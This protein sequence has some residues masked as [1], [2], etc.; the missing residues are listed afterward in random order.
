MANGFRR[1][2]RADERAHTAAVG[3]VA[4]MLI[5]G[6]T[7]AA[8]V[9]FQNE[10][11]A[12]HDAESEDLDVKARQALGLIVAQSGSTSTGLA[13]WHSDADRL[14]RFGLAS[15][16]ATRTLEYGKI[17]NLRSSKLTEDGANAIADY[18]EV[19]R[20]LGLQGYNIHL[21]SYPVLLSMEDSR[22]T[23]HAD[24]RPAYVAQYDDPVAPADVTHSVV[25]QA[26]YVEPG[27][28]ITNRHVKDAIYQVTF[29]LNTTGQ[30]NAQV[31]ETHYTKLLRPGDTDYVWTRYYP[32][33]SWTSPTTS[34]EVRVAD[35]YMA[36]AKDTSGN[37]IGQRFFN[38]VSMPASGNE[39]YNLLVHADDQH[40]VSGETVTILGDHF[41]KDGKRSNQGIQGRLTVTRPDGTVHFNGTLDLE[42]NKPG[43]YECTT[44]TMVGNWS[45]LLTTTS[46]AR[47][48]RDSFHVS[49][50]AMF[51]ETSGPDPIAI[52]EQGYV[53]AIAGGSFDATLYD[54]ATNPGGDVFRASNVR[55]L[56]D[57]LSR[58]NI[59]II[60]SKFRQS[61]LEPHA[62]KEG[63]ANWVNDTGGTLV[64][65][66]SVAQNAQ[67][68]QPLYGAGIHNANGGVSAPDPGHP[69]LHAPEGLAY[70]SYNDNGKAWRLKQDD[71]Y[72]HVLSKGV[73]NQGSED[74][75]AVSKPGVFGDGS[76]ILSTYMPG[77]LMTPQSDLE[78]KKFLHN[79]MSQSYT[80]LFLD[81]GPAI[82]PGV[83]V[84]S[85][86]RLAAIPHPSVPG[87]IV[88][89]QVVLYV[90]R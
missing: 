30:Q 73:G 81:F 79:L 89:V 80:M 24:M 72:T 12:G 61:A 19:L 86:T 29:V 42:K 34:I 59:L 14:Q 53:T 44:C 40:Y 32:I 10:P 87:A 83:P 28:T 17:K 66:G 88:E 45:V 52:T 78:G 84:G 3:F 69:I 90:F 37:T 23:A 46:G 11:L 15:D 47:G 51:T 67:W 20:G 50:A 31:V 55:E 64:V 54:P 57:V 62:V 33:Q 43:K 22:W 41:D 71:Y 75:L 2:I 77:S 27:A 36:V 26:T 58:Y 39:K 4:S 49:A 74:T 65:L 9:Q 82:P 63:I 18:P 68:L 6:A 5:F 70:Q 60:G 1:R 16:P 48:Q 56:P 7:F 13:A 76:V 25:A 21:R 35:S 8:V 38:G 85:S